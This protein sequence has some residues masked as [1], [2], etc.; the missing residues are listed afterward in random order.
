MN[1]KYENAQEFDVIIVGAG[2]AGM[3]CGK[4]L[5]GK[6][7]KTAILEQNNRPGKKISVS[8]GGRCNITNLNI[9]V[10]DF[11]SSNRHFPKSALSRCSSEEILNEFKSSGL[12][13]HEKKKGQMFCNQ[14][15]QG[16]L[17]TLEKW[18]NESKVDIQLDCPIIEVEHSKNKF[19]LLSANGNIY[20][21]NKLVLATG[22]LSF[23]ALGVSDIGLKVA[24]QFGHK[25]VPVRPALVPFLAAGT[26]LQFC[27]SLT[28]I[29]ISE[30]TISIGGKVIQDDLLFTHKGI[31]GPVSLKASLYWNK[32]DSLKIDFLPNVD[33]EKLLSVDQKRKKKNIL[34]EV[35]PTR[36]VEE[37]I[38]NYDL[39]FLENSGLLNLKQLKQLKDILHSFVFTP[40]GLDTFHKAEVM[41]GGVSVDEVSSKTMESKKREGLFFIGEVLDVTGQ[42]GGYNFQ[43]AWASAKA[44]GVAIT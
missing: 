34:I 32:G 26:E 3:Y 17:Q 5:G 7:L 29:S 40:K 43:W 4:I 28:G 1:I 10:D 31:S 36:L 9:A 19:R 12:L 41:L 14:K 27:T 15:S 16:V 22:G 30:V 18:L 33:L 8:G 38:K 20:I 39:G 21:C 2:A 37:L 25:I 35:L 23:P 11:V 44:C 13:F 42:L 6:G 24:K